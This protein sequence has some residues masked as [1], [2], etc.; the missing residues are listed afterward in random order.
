MT[1]SLLLASA[2][3]ALA[4]P[5]AL[6]ATAQTVA[7]VNARIEPVSSAA[8]PSG[9]LVIKDGKIAALG[10]NV[11]IPAGATV[12]DAKGG[13][14]TPG[15]VASSSN[16]SAS[17]IGG[18]RETR[19]DG[20]G[21]ALSAAF[22][23]SY[24]VNPAS[25]MIGLA[26]DGGVTSSAVVPV[27]SGTGGGASEHADD[28]VVEE[29]TA[30]KDG[31]GDP[32]LFGGQAAFI[33]LKAGS[34]DIVEAA[35]LAVTV[36]LGESGARAAGGSRGADLVLIR[37]ALEDARAFASRRAA[38]EQGATRDFGLSRLDLAALIPVVQ[39]KTPLLIRVSRAADIR[40]A[41]KLAAE[42]KIKIILEGVEEG[43]MVA[44]E[45]AKAGVPVIVDPQADLPDSFEALGSRLDNAARLNAAGVSVAINGARDFNNLRQERLNAGLAVANGLPYAAGLASVTLT[46]AKIWGQDGKIGSLDVGKVAD[47]V[48]WNGD[49]LE[50]T[51]WPLN[52]FVGGVEQPK[53]SR[54]TQ[55]RDRYATT[56]A[57]GYPP[58]YR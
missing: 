29:M 43:W 9:T 12:I 21:S 53:D 49:P 19:D 16:L 22:D 46:P 17:E 35:K 58:A 13:V 38:F 54:Q 24:S 47:V 31:A 26:R 14:V 36:S 5:L 4:L 51:S 6:P 1:R 18:V 27:L 2:A 41:L 7:I 15:L 32:P 3:C 42:E 55:L 52:V 56:D 33:R 37:S 8:I 50:T 39:G 10:P 34:P 44:A 45:I 28:G 57:S 48:V 11:A 40:Q 20:T 23:I 25:P 30:G